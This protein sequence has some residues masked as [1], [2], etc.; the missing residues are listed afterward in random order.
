MSLGRRCLSIHACVK[1]GPC[2]CLA[3]IFL[4]FLT[5]ASK[6]LLAS[7]FFHPGRLLHGVD[8]DVALKDEIRRIKVVEIEVVQLNIHVQPR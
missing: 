6:S 3:R 7:G 1:F 2:N 8:G 5:N 4:P